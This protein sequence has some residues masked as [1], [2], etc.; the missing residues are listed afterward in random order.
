MVSTADDIRQLLL[1]SSS[2][3]NGLTLCVGSFASREDND[4]V[5]MAEEFANNTHFVHLRNVS[6]TTDGGFTESNHLEGD[7]DMFKVLT[8]LLKEKMR[9]SDGNNSTSK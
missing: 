5:E 9:R 4:V 3:S 7:V 2:P 6:K 1:A 8:I